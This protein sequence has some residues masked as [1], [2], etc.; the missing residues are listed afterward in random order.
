MCVGGGGGGG[1]GETVYR[2]VFRQ[3][4]SGYSKPGRGGAFS[5]WVHVRPGDTFL[6]S[7]VTQLLRSLK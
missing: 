5:T 3:D 4:Q 2:R 1:G 7:W 6:A